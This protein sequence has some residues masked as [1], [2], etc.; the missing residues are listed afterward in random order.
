MNL[1]VI[2][3]VVQYQDPARVLSFFLGANDNGILMK[4]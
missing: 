2:R 3:F 1:T 4:V